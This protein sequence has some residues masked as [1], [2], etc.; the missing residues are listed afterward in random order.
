HNQFEA[1][2]VFGSEFMRQKRE[3]AR[4]A[5]AEAR[6]RVEAKAQAVKEEEARAMKEQEARARAMKDQEARALAR[7]QAK[8]VLA[9]LRGLGCRADQAKRAAQFVETLSCETLEERMRAALGFISRASARYSGSPE[10]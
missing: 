7:E 4:L 3:E 8:D 1:E 9:G 6:K 5:A 10:T 2:R